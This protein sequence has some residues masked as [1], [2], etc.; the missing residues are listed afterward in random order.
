MP[1]TLDTLLQQWK[2]HE[3]AAAVAA[4]EDRSVTAAATLG[5][6]YWRVLARTCAGEPWRRFTDTAWLR[7]LV[8]V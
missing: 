5:P 1:D 3:M 8:A 2:R 4:L 7:R 6:S